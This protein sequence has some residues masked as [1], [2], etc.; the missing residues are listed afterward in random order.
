MTMTNPFDKFISESKIEEEYLQELM[1]KNSF[2]KLFYTKYFEIVGNDSEN[3]FK[4]GAHER[5]MKNYLN[6][7]QFFHEIY[8]ED[9][10][11]DL[12][13]KYVN[14]ILF[15]IP[16][17]NNGYNLIY[18][19]IRNNISMNSMLN[20]ISMEIK[21]KSEKE[22][23]FLEYRTINVE[24]KD[25]LKMMNEIVDHGEQLVTVSPLRFSEFHNKLVRIHLKATIKNID[26]S[27]HIL[28]VPY[29]KD[30]IEVVEPS[31]SYELAEWATTVKNCVYSYQK[32]ILNESAAIFLLKENGK[33]K[34]T[35]EIKNPK[36]K[37]A[38][39]GQ[40]EKIYKTSMTPEERERVMN[41]VHEILEKKQS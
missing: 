41:L 10:N 1:N 27:Q 36:S 5:M 9:F 13:L 33:P 31:N 20:M 6:V 32:D 14:Q 25:I 24:F 35:V 12:I 15:F 30:N 22:N 29:Q 39:I 4:I 7:I 21:R 34:F 11:Y 40:V 17:T 23:P 8:Q 2:K 19:W 28:K 37:T 26:Y 16:P 38:S 18:C 3:K